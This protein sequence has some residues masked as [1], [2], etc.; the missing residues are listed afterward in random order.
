M[1]LAGRER[2][3]W[4]LGTS[5]AGLGLQGRSLQARRLDDAERRRFVSA[6]TTIYELNRL[7][8]GTH[9]TARTDGALKGRR[10]KT[11]TGKDKVE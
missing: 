10:D 11:E 8:T 7:R 4:P 9:A 2:R 3:K 1:I 6:M 5:A